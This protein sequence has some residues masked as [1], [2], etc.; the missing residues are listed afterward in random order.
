[1]SAVLLP[2]SQAGRA[3]AETA[4]SRDRSGACTRSRA[5]SRAHTRTRSCI[6]ERRTQSVHGTEPVCTPTCIYKCANPPVRTASST[7]AAE[8]TSPTRARISVHI[9]TLLC[10]HTHSP[11]VSLHMPETRTNLDRDLQGVTREYPGTQARVHTDPPA[12]AG[13]HTRVHTTRT[14]THGASRAHSFPQGT[15]LVSPPPPP[16]S[17][18]WRD[19]GGG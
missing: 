3:R 5:H 7:R 13:A 17:R 1:M 15:R 12:Q 10:T 14:R 9:C 2:D 19:G 4:T 18:G 16:Q 6:S 11:R 8:Y